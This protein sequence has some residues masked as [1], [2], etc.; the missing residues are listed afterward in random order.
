VNGAR[1]VAGDIPGT[2][3]LVGREKERR[4]VD[5]LLA[6]V[7]QRCCALVLRGEPGVG[8]S[9]LLRYAERMSTAGVLWLR[10]VES[11]AVLPFATLADLVLPLREH[12]RHLPDAQRGA[13]EVCLAL[14]EGSLASPYAACAGTL[15]LLAAAGEERPL[16]VLV[17]DLQW[18]DEPSR[19]VLLFVARRLAAERVAMLLAVRSDAAWMCE[20]SG[21]PAVEIGGLP[22]EACGE[23]LAAEGVQVVPRVLADLVRRVGGN[24]SALLDAVASL[25]ATQLGGQEP[26]G[27]LPPPGR[28]LERAWSER[29][30]ELPEA[31]RAALVVLAAGNAVPVATL[32]RALAAMSGSLADLDA[33]H[34]AGLVEAVELGSGEPAYRPASD[35]PGGTPAGREHGLALTH[36]LLRAVVLRRATPATRLRACQALAEVCD[37][38]AGVWY[39]AAA[40]SGPDDRVSAA[41]AEVAVQA[42]RRA[43]YGASARAWHR[44]AEL[45]RARDLRVERFLRAAEDAHLG[46]LASQAAVWADEAARLAVD[47]AVRAEVELVRGRVLTWSGHPTRAHEQL[48]QAAE[49]VLERDPDRAGDLLAEAV[50]PALMDGRTDVALRTAERGLLLGSASPRQALAHTVHRGRALALAGLTGE[51]NA[52]LGAVAGQLVAADDVTD[53][54]T[55]TLAGQTRLDLEDDRAA[56]RL[57]SAVVD[58]ARRAE[59]PAMLPYA[60][61]VRCEL[62]GWRGLW[63]AGYADG[64]DAL[65]WA[66]ELGQTAALG[67]SLSM[68]ARID[69]ARGDRA[70]CEQRIARLRA[71][72]GPYGIGMLDLHA[73]AVLGLAAIGHGEYDVAALTLADAWSRARELGLGNPNAIPLAADLA[74]A[75]IRA[76]EHERAARVVDWLGERARATGLAWPTAVA[77]RCRGLLADGLRAAEAAFDE[78]ERAHRCRRMP[79]EQARTRLCHGEVLRRLRRPAAARLPLREARVAFESLGAR[80][81]ARRAT[82]ELVAAGDRAGQAVRADRAAQL[83]ARLDR[84]TPAEV[85]VARTICDGMNNAEAAAALFVSR[86]TVETHLTRVY[87]KLGVRSR[88]ELVRAL[89]DAGVS[90][91]LSEA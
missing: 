67:F 87:R 13:L 29:L 34:D 86:K 16:V 84:L 12:L 9:A 75:H 51:A 18:V 82:A 46:G 24:P 40:A 11:E 15:N 37:G 69:A 45:T 10:G 72:T 23:L 17:D 50:L 91:V 22:P 59:A 65:R 35:G 52:C 74:E 41:L 60:L 8:K 70:L 77:A 2:Y 30:D 85:Q 5:G 3:T 4:L 20:G 58:A 68:L 81:W 54:Q 42:R 63:A 49:S 73:D 38:D 28:R 31:T 78:A 32:G 26:V 53:Q 1:A 27:E 64:V 89:V 33:A 36:P 44:A 7:A 90:D 25:R 83:S 19:Q 61:A 55:L 43:G 14:A 39:A 79:F 57:L 80:P 71:E 76:G 62:E 47:P 48:V 56:V 21:L 6:A 88:S 66:E